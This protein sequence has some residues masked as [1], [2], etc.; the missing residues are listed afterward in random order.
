MSPSETHTSVTDRTPDLH[1]EPTVS[2]PGTQLW[3]KWDDGTESM[4]F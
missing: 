2:R 3:Y 1:N 4:Y